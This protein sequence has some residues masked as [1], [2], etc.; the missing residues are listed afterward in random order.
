MKYVH[1]RFI[2]LYISPR[3]YHRHL[4]DVTGSVAQVQCIFESLVAAAKPQVERVEGHARGVESFGYNCRTER[5]VVE[6][7]G[8]D[9]EI[10]ESVALFAED[11]VQDIV[12]SGCK[13]ESQR[14]KGI[15]KGGHVE[16]T[17]VDLP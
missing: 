14:G 11:A 15:L 8:R 13:I 6:G 17:G 10:G 12:S 1:F 5:F 16:T 2:I 3:P 4:V 7:R 9:G